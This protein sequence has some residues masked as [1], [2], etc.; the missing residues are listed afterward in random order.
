MRLGAVPVSAPWVGAVT[1]VKVTDERG[2]EPVSVIAL[3]PVVEITWEFA[4]AKP[5]ACAGAVMAF[6]MEAM[7]LT[8]VVYSL[9]VGLHFPK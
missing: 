1:L 7:V 2:D 8:S 3:E 9:E 5:G 6:S 4:T